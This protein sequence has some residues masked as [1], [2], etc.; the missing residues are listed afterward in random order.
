MKTSWFANLPTKNKVVLG[1][2]TPL[3]LMGLVG[4]IGLVGLWHINRT[5]NWVNHTHNVLAEASEIVAG[6]V[7][8][9]TGMR[10]FLLSGQDAFLDPYRAGEDRTYATIAELQTTVSDNPGQVA[11]LGEVEQVLREWQSNVTE[12]QIALRREI[13]DAPTMN[14]MAR[15]VGEARGKAY[16][17]TFRGRIATFIER[18][19]V[20][21][22]Q[23][24]S[25]FENSLRNGSVSAASTQ[26]AMNW[27]VHT[28][29]VIGRANALLA[30]AIDMETGM[31]GY[32]LSGQQEFLEPF[33]SGRD[34]FASILEELKETVSDNPAQVT[35]LGEIGT[36]ID[37]W[38]SEIVL[39]TI[40]FRTSIGDAKTMDDMADLVAEARG[41]QYFD[42]F[43]GLMAAFTEEE[44]A[45]MEER[46]ASRAATM[47]F[48]VIGIFGTMLIAI[49]AGGFA[50]TKIGNSIARPIVDITKAIRGLVDGAGDVL[51]EGQDRQDEV[52]DIARAAQVF[53][54]NA[55]K[56]EQLARADAEKSK[57]L[58]EAS[59]AQMQEAKARE[60]E[61]REANARAATRQEMMTRLQTSISEVV[62]GAAEGQFTNR[63]DD[64]FED[65]DLRELAKGINRLMSVVGDSLEST[66]DVL[67]RFADGDLG[68][69][70]EGA[71]AG[72]LKELQTNLNRTIGRLS[73]L[74]GDISTVAT[75]I[76]ADAQEIDTAAS[77]LSE[78]TSEQAAAVEETAAAMEEMSATVKSNA[79]N[80][81]EARE[82]AT[83]ASEK[84]RA[85]E[86]IVE[87]AVGSISEIEA[88]SK[89]VADIVSLIDDIAFQ[90]N[91]LAL[92][93]SVEAARAGDAGK[94]FAVVASE[95]RGLAQRTS[96]ASNDIRDLIEV[97]GQAI[98][99][100][101]KMISQTGTSL[102]EILSSIE[103]VEETMKQI[104]VSSEEQ[105]QGVSEVSATVTSF[106]QLTQKNASM[107]LQSAETAASLSRGAQQLD[108][109]LAYFK[110]SA[111]TGMTSAEANPDSRA[112]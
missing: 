92:N 83:D 82:L 42:S 1:A 88:S 41:K 25:E 71:Y 59:D 26:E 7:D 55:E 65:Q 73:E 37:E 89:K 17:D 10:G 46:E 67:S 57:A 28:Y 100:G 106:D 94:G 109:L 12:M 95:V 11:R 9:E 40:E 76:T 58:Q 69:R 99:D 102:G 35:L 74:V 47:L 107:A 90:T 87:K 112:A 98:S 4:V 44:R 43:R 39:P 72:S 62:A 38:I 105:A 33:E 2:S 31:R 22:V 96:D 75:D 104:A 103:R 56:V 14:D 18:E 24:Q 21:L 80:S 61:Q 78:R 49:L 3:I 27:V 13:G 51:I 101:V 91:L 16:F 5:S 110:Q 66:V 86:Q 54:E 36:G 32:L 60:Q 30:S 111:E 68:T 81:K 20:L 77:S 19:E 53:K 85:G 93:A 6:A 23:R 50:A 64:S 79:Q 48:A 84:A 70:M 34:R 45:L 108:Q 63:V 8:M 52:G 15:L 97:S 29:N